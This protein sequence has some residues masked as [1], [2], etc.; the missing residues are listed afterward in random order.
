MYFLGCG[1]ETLSDFFVWPSPV[2]VDKEGLDGGLLL[3][4]E[5]MGCPL[6]EWNTGGVFNV[7][8]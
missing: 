5:G 3:S 7:V 2:V 1:C 6:F 4:T 8:V